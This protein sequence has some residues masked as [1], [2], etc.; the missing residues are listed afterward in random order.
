M[1]DETSN[2]RQFHEF[3]KQLP[4]DLL[5]FL[6]VKFVA[7]K[8]S[9][10]QLPPGEGFQSRNSALGVAMELVNDREVPSLPMA[11]ELE[12]INQVLVLLRFDVDWSTQPA[13]PAGHFKIAFRLVNVLMATPG[14]VPFKVSPDTAA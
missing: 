3:F 1:A 10:T 13:P 5:A 9:P 4:A 11:T 8:L 6:R 7:T 2:V 12:A 14:M